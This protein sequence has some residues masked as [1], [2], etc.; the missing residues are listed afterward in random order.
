VQ[1][2]TSSKKLRILQ[3]GFSSENGL[4]PSRLKIAHKEQ[5]KFCSDNKLTSNPLIIEN[6]SNLR[7]KL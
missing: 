6:I 3:G 1:K 4:F 7:D 2:A 5:S